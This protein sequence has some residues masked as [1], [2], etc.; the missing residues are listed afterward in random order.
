[1]IYILLNSRFQSLSDKFKWGTS[2]SNDICCANAGD[3]HESVIS[4]TGSYGT[5]AMLVAYLNKRERPFNANMWL[6]TDFTSDDS[7]VGWSSVDSGSQLLIRFEFQN[8]WGFGNA[9]FLFFLL[10]LNFNLSFS[11]FMCAHMNFFECSFRL[12]NSGA[13]GANISNSIYF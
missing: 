11:V 8:Q 2:S 13:T 3:S 1:M 6:A 10:G 12:A 7:R 5:G 9:S 4:K